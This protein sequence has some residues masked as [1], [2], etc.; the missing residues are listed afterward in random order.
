MSIKSWRDGYQRGFLDGV[1][2]RRKWD[3]ENDAR[4]YTVDFINSKAFNEMMFPEKCQ[5]CDGD[6]KVCE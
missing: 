3:E 5:E 2:M 6:C 4:Y 1:E